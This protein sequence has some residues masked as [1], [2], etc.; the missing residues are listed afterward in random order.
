MRAQNLTTILSTAL[1]LTVAAAGVAHGQEA[2]NRT[3]PLPIRDQAPL[4]GVPIGAIV[5]FIGPL[6]TLPDAWLPCDGRTVDDPSSPIHGLQ[7]PDLSDGRFLMGIGAAS[8]IGVTGGSNA[9]SSAGGHSH[10]GEATSRITQTSG[11]PRNLE[12][13][14][15]KGFRHTHALTISSSGGH[16]HGGD[17]RPAFFGVHYIVRVK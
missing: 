1:L 5:P 17:N 13:R 2:S 10:S 9:I 4:V 7:L 12:Q 15:D 14:G 16:D 8:M 3:G 11:T 6:D